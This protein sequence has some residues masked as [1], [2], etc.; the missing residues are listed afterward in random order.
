MPYEDYLH[1]RSD[2]QCLKKD[3]TTRLELKLS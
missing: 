2:L 1:V 3:L